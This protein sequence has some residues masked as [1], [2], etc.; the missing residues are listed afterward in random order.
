MKTLRSKL[1]YANVISTVALFLVI[2]GGAAYAASLGKN[3]VGT[4]QI[5]NGAVTGN[6]IKKHTITGKQVNLGKL[7]TVPSANN[8]NTATSAGTA[9][10]LSPPEAIHL[11]GM[12]GQP[13]FEGG[14]VG[15]GEPGV[16]FQPVGFYKDK[17]GIVHLE[18]VVKV[19]REKGSTSLVPVFT[20]PAGFR[21]AN[22]VVQIFNSG[23]P[24]GPLVA[25]SDA[26]YEGHGLSGNVLGSEGETLVLSGITFRAGG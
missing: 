1:T 6:K 2:S 24:S 14:S 12:P 21:P 17:E 13:A 22:G 19:G 3:S 25:G 15:D 9:N 11:V 26:S 4:K 18:G 20:L 5:K 10:A 7:G 16:T 8:A 23:P